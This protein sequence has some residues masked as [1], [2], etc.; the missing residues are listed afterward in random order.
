M[1]VCVYVCTCMYAYE[2]K[3]STIQMSYLVGQVI[4]KFQSSA[5]TFSVSEIGLSYMH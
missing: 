3:W 2:T 1:Y 5:V 4:I